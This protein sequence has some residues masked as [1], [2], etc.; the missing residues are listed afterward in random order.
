MSSLSSWV[1]LMILDLRSLFER[2][3]KEAEESGDPL[4]TWTRY[5]TH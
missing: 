3:L 4:S 5:T 1:Y 2:E